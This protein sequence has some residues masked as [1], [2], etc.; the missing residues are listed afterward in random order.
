MK[1]KDKIE[2]P[3]MGFMG[4]ETYIGTIVGINYTYYIIDF[5]ENTA[6]DERFQIRPKKRL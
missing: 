3:N 5:G 6:I 1:L 2:V 4:F